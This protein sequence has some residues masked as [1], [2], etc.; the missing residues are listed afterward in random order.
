M[1]YIQQDYNG[2]F[3]VL[4]EHDLGTGS[5]W[6]FQAFFDQGGEGTI[7]AG[8]YSTAIFDFEYNDWMYV[9][10]MVDLDNDW[11][12][13]AINDDLIYEWQWSLGIA[14]GSDYNTLQAVDWYSWS[15]QCTSQIF[16]G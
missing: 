6:G 7:D 8:G 14:G 9:E 4:Q 13:F 1:L 5:H 3:N 12:E 15:S 2:Y 11:A 10:V 16:Y